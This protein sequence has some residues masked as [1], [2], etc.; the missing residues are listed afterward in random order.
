M[1]DA[2]EFPGMLRAVIPLVRRQRF[3]RLVRRVVDELVAI[4]RWRSTGSGRLAVRRSRLMPR[5]S[6]VVR[7]LDD[8]AEPSAGLRGVQPVRVRRRPLEMVD[9][10]TGKVRAA[11]IPFFPLAV[12][13]KNKC[14]FSCANKYAN[15]THLTGSFEKFSPFEL[16]LSTKRRAMHFHFRAG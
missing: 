9:L 6:A 16:N 2:L 8:L 4:T 12:R 10:P 3:A 1:P 7:T 5:L 14:A 11:D 15:L 13:R